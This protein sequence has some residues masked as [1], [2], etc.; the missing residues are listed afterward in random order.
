MRIAS[1]A[2]PQILVLASTLIITMAEAGDPA[3]IASLS[4]QLNAAI[5][6]TANALA[7]MNAA[8]E[9]AAPKLKEIKL[10]N[11]QL[12]GYKPQVEAMVQRRN[13]HNVD[14]DVVN[15][16]V[17]THNA[18]C[19]GT[20]P[21]PQYERCKG[22]ESSLQ[23]EINRINNQ[24]ARLET[25]RSTL[26]RR[27]TDIENRRDTLVTSLRSIKSTYDEAK[28]RFDAARSRIES[29]ASRLRKECASATTPE[30]MAYCAQID[31]DGTQ[32]GLPARDL[33][34]RPFT[35]TPNE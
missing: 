18:H 34:P 24:Q 10:W 6:E 27:V 5:T 32:Q 13:A 28:S 1:K 12:D 16:N 9:D 4:S 21:R 35:I 26:L 29:L 15:Q 17:S 20:L 22:E 33:R 25:D 31:W 7:D 14:A 23:G 11:E 19:S 2:A 3:T 8:E 30:A